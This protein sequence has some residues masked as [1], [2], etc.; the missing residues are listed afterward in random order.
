MNKQEVV[1]LLQLLHSM[2]DVGDRIEKSYEMNN[3]EELESAKKEMTSLQKKIDE[4]LK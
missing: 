4:T 3:F 2:K 1:L